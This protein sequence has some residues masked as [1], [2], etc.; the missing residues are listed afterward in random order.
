MHL[1]DGQGTFYTLGA[2]NGVAVR[3]QHRDMDRRAAGG[4]DR[5]LHRAVHGGHYGHILDVLFGGGVE[6]HRAVDARIVEEVKVRA[7]LGCGGALGGLH[8]GDARIV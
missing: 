2:C 8:T 7:V 4:F 1:R 6:H 5:V 3:I